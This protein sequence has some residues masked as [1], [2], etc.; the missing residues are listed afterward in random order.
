MGDGAIWIDR[1]VRPGRL[2]PQPI[3]KTKRKKH[4][5]FSRTR[6]VINEAP[7]WALVIDQSRPWLDAPRRR[8]NFLARACRVRSAPDQGVHHSRVRRLLA[9]AGVPEQRHR[10]DAGGATGGAV[11]V[12]V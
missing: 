1:S 3:S 11:G 7:P 12:V 8:A 5:A 6:F 9:V 2:S 10:Q 4:A